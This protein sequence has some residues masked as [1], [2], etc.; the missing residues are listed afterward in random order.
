MRKMTVQ[1]HVLASISDTPKLRSEIE[2]EV[3]IHSHRPINSTSLGKALK[4]ALEKGCAV[5]TEDGKYMEPQ[6]HFC[7]ANF[8]IRP[9]SNMNERRSQ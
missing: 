7:E 1:D 9:G 6:D 2:R 3:A 8:A 4:R 5:K